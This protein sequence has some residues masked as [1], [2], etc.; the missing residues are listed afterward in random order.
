MRNIGVITSG[1]DAPGMNASLRAIV[2]KAI[3]NGLKTMGIE[4]GYAGLLTDQIRPLGLR[5]VS[6]IVHLGGTILRTARCPE[7]KTEEGLRKAGEVLSKHGIRD[8]I[9]IGGQGSFKGA[10][11]LSDM[12]GINIIGVPASID[13]DVY[14][15]DETIGFDTAVN[16]AL[17]AIDKIRD[18][19]TSLSRVFVV[20]TMGR[21]RGF[22]ALAVGLA[23]GAEE[24][25]VPEVKT[26]MDEVYKRI[27]E[28]REKGKKSNIVVVAEGFGNS[29]KIAEDIEKNTGYEVRLT[30][31]GYI[32]RGGAPTA[33]SRILA[34]LFGS[35]AVELILSG[36][37]NK[38]VGLSNGKV[39]STDL[40][41]SCRSR[42][43]LNLDLLRLAEELAV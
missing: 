33:R 41:T 24:I 9:V 37:E 30:V 34:N 31:L 25:L 26:D 2:R 40:A 43:R 14:G 12:F 7:F 28:S 36:E 38:V 16:T 27:I 21:D 17:S 11:E 42:K 22:L 29:K 5:S 4:N 15:T 13:N 18:T 32:Q 8:L 3:P 23:A 35:K 6:G 19:A 39:I 1:G 20:E 10:L